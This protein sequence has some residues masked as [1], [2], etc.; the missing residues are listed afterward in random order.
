MGCLMSVFRKIHRKVQQSLTWLLG[1]DGHGGG[2]GSRVGLSCSALNIKCQGSPNV[3][4]G[5]CS[6]QPIN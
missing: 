1:D 5:V 3:M 4:V 6:S 2:E